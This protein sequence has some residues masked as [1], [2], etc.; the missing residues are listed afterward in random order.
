VSA[1]EY[2]YIK[3]VTPPKKNKSIA[4]PNAPPLRIVN[5]T[6]S[7][8]LPPSANKRNI[9]KANKRTL[10]APLCHMVTESWF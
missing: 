4:F 9:H 8:I 5:T 7:K 2:I 6:L 1:V 10:L 3:S